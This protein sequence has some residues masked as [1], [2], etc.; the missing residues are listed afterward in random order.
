MKISSHSFLMALLFLCV[1]VVVA[2]AA[3]AVALAVGEGAVCGDLD[4]NP[5]TA[6]V[7]CDAT[8][9][10]TGGF[11][12]KEI[13]LPPGDFRAGGDL[14]VP[15]SGAAILGRIQLIANW[16]FAFFLAISLIYIIMAAFQFVTAGA[17][18][19][20]IDQARQKLLYAVIGIAIGLLVFGIPSIIRNIVV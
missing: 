16:V 3:P 9:V 12:I 18:P 19:A 10:C 8:L 15:T 17:E 2:G 14:Q 1:A 6:S 4:N 11:C 7:V 20:K 13:D 5:V